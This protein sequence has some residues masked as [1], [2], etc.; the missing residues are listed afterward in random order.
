MANFYNPYNYQNYLPYQ[1]YQQQIQPQQQTIHNGGLVNVQSEQEAR[2]YPVAP[3]TS[4]TFHNENEPYIYT[5][6]VGS[7]LEPPKFEKFKLVREEAETV[8]KM[9][10]VETEYLKTEDFLSKLNDF[11]SVYA[12]NE[13][14]ISI[15]DEI[16]SIKKELKNGR[17]TSTKSA[18]K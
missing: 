9:E 15:K 6:T 5:K 3:Q 14:L 7:S 18:K 16:E 13:D 11:E 1:N 17:T 8:S 10:N 2:N 4:V 12:K